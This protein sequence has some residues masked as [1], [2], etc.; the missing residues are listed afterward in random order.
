MTP[1]SSFPPLFFL[2]SY[3][4]GH[5]RSTVKLPKVALPR[6]FAELIDVEGNGSAIKEWVKLYFDTTHKCFPIGR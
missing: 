4:F 1:S 3:T 2:D 5:R 6:E